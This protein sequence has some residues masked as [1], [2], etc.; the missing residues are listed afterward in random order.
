MSN[1]VI[2]APR[3]FDHNGGAF[4]FRS[5]TTIAYINVDVAPIVERFC[6]DVTRRTGGRVVVSEP[7]NT[8][9]RP[10]CSLKI[11]ALNCKRKA[12]PEVRAQ[13]DADVAMSSRDVRAS[14]R[15][16]LRIILRH[17]FDLYRRSA[18]ILSFAANATFA[19]DT[20]AWR[21]VAS[22]HPFDTCR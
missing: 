8:S 20:D 3:R 16:S 9:E 19:I 2:P 12:R 15:S 4:A 17:E 18:S 21:F 11:L 6:L 14:A 5:G 13:M 22:G 1:A 7:S 10:G